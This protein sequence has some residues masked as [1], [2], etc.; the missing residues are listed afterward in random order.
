MKRVQ[1]LFAACAMS[2]AMAAL[3]QEPPTKTPHET[4]EV[5]AT[6]IAED[7]MVV[8]ASVT[9]VDG[10]DIRARNANDLQSA[11]ALVAGVS[12]APGGDGGPAGSVPEMWGLREFDAF[13]LV[14]DGVPWGGA[15]NPD[16]AALNLQN[17]DR[18][19]V[20]RGAA[21]VMYGATS[22]VGV[23]HVI[24]RHPG[25][26]GSGRLS[27]GNLR[28]GGAAVSVPISQGRDLQ[29]SINLDYEKRGFRDKN[30]NFD[31][32]HLLY[33]YAS[34]L[35]GG[36]LHFDG[37][38]TLLQQDPASPHPREGPG[39]SPNVP[40][41]ANYNPGNGRLDEHRYHAVV[42]FDGQASGMP[43][44]TTL[45][46][47]RSNHGIVRGF[48][49]SISDS[50]PNVAG[51]Q[52]ERKVTDVYF[53]THV[54]K[55]VTPLL[56]V[57]AGFD[58]LY[59]RAEADSGLFDYFVPLSGAGRPHSPQP[60]EKT[61][62]SDSRNFSGLYAATEWT[63]MPRLRVDAGLRLNHTSEKRHGEAD[64]PAGKEGSSD[65]RTFTRLSGSIGTN[66]RL[67]SRDR[68]LLA[69]YAD[70]RQTF[71]P[72]AIDFGPDAEG[73]ILDAETAHS[74][75]VGIKGRS[76]GG[77]LAWDAS[78]FQMD[79]S[80]LVV[81]TLVNGLPALA[82]AGHE[83]FHGA[84]VE[85]DYGIRDDL[86]W[87]VGYSYHDARFRDY[88]QNFDGTAT[89]L[90]GKRLEMIPFNLFNT[91]VRY[92]LKG[93]LNANV[94]A[95]YAGERFLNRRNTAVAKAYTTW[96]AGV[97]YPIGRGEVRVDGRNLTNQ[98]PPVSE[99]EM[100]D[101]QY[102]LLP[103]RSWEVSYRVNF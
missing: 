55:Q 69:L 45:A 71:K 23:I 12:I 88:V 16:T 19:E 103:A 63:V 99:S 27:L 74:V 97:G 61:H 62:L 67:W 68:D 34:S 66:W 77:K 38:V 3:A 53:D 37:D 5:T 43:W 49:S 24:H 91:G 18:I 73:R 32:A 29:Q 36:T 102:Y 92:W 7:V 56:R 89:Q 84:E 95:N 57:I 79:F 59:G 21:P 81:A 44:T 13:L 78:T 47:T 51:F 31:R 98:R 64:G 54:V 26:S 87:M 33:R 17:V 10:D 30:T 4:I 39:L 2:A 9:V 25:A 100:G 85:F 75:E 96:S 65:S 11:L 52:Q 60:D 48:L 15:F 6:R 42:G 50:N 70:Y 101:A 14:V 41:D 28:S 46:L 72:A 94:A 86:H 8:P 82:N 83:R 80:N 1:A 40:I 93:G 76:L 22:F 20:L 58:H 90:A 35:A